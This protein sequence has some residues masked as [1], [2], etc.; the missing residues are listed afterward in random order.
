MVLHNE[1]VPERHGMTL[2]DAEKL[3]DLSP[4]DTD[5][6]FFFSTNPDTSIEQAINHHVLFGIALDTFNGEM[7]EEPATLPLEVQQSFMSDLGTAV[8]SVIAVVRAKVLAVRLQLR[9][10][11]PINPMNWKI[12]WNSNFARW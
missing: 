11:F 2:D 1:L 7:T 9:H 3:S 5:P 10:Q 4:W 8:I 12:R 6:Q